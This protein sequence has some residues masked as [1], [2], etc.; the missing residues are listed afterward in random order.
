MLIFSP[1]VGTNLLAGKS[2][3]L[4]SATRAMSSSG[5]VE[6]E[7]IHTEKRGNVG[8]VVS[9]HIHPVSAYA[10]A[11]VNMAR[12]AHETVT[13]F[14]RPAHCDKHVPYSHRHDSRLL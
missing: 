7:F 11:I 10:C 12:F 14:V 3:L 4:T 1:R 5:V 8:L 6:K 2:S 9:T 13:Q